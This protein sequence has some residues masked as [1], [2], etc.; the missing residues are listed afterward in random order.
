MEAIIQPQLRRGLA[1]GG[2]V[3]TG[4]C[5]D[6]CGGTPGEEDEFS[7]TRKLA[8]SRPGG[9]RRFEGTFQRGRHSR[10]RLASPKSG[11]WAFRPAAVHQY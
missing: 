9:K 5:G 1:G 3:I 7:M 10:A 4:G 2:G 11:S 8:Q 6:N